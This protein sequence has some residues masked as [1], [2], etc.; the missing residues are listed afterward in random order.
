VLVPTASALGGDPNAGDVWVDNVGQ[1]PGPGHEMDPHLACQN[2]NLWGAGLADSSGPYTIDGWPP[3]GSQEQDYSGSWN[4][5]QSKG[6]SQVL[7]VINVQTLIDTAIAHG[8]TPQANQGF[9]F[10]LQFSAD[11][12]K[13]KTFWVNCQLP[14][15]ATHAASATAGQPIHDVAVL[16]G[17]DAPSGSITWNVYKASD[18]SCATSLAA[19]TDAVAGDGTYTSPDFTPSAIGAYQWVATYSGDGSNLTATTACNDP[20]EQSTVSKANPSIATTATS[21]TDGHPIHDVATLSGGDSP[22]GTITWNVYVADTGCATSLDTVSVPVSGDGIYTSPDFTPSA[23]G[24]YQWVAT[25]SGDANNNLIAS[26]CNDPNERSTIQPA[27]APG[28]SLIKLERD[29][30]AGSFVRGPIT[31]NVGDTIDYQ[32]TVINTGNTDLVITFSDQHCDVGTLSAPVIVRGTFDAA[33]NTLSAGGELQYTCTHLLVL[34]DVPQFTNTASVSGQPPS[35][36]PVSA[37][38]SVVTVLNLP[39]MTVVKLQ[40]DGGTGTFTTGTINAHVGDT[41]QYAIRVTNTGNTPLALSLSDP[42]CDAGTVT[43]PFAISG[44]LTGT[45]LSPGGV[46]QYRC[47]HVLKASDS[48]PFTNT[49]TVTGRPPSG[50]P[51]DGTASV[52]VS[53]QALRPI[54]IVR[55][56]AGK[57]KRT[58]KHHGRAVTVCIARKHKKSVVIHRRIEPPRFTG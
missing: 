42:H 32:M 23:T 4:Y 3:S 5:N 51:V 50:P 46:A 29:E 25:Y 48:S 11:P 58:R 49:A 27:P 2:I 54:K 20:N 34:S 24:T 21:N 52:T 55:C 56:P 37:S 35:G 12:Q 13:H 14:T 9:H 17:G 47:S 30:T 53:K 7:D 45:A 38:S 40:R 31:G 15:I 10:K 43:G 8:D 44:T 1:P 19:V 57:V 26:S 41:I 36:P 33:S 18:T 16:S 6:G 39:A 22:T 28:I